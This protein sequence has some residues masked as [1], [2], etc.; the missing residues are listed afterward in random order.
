[1]VNG[2]YRAP[3]APGCSTEIRPESLSEFAFPHGAGWTEPYV[4]EEE[5]VPTLGLVPEMAIEE[6][7]QE[8]REQ[9]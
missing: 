3:R 6:T 5:E 4:R 9:Q 7:R 2:F 8:W 1:M